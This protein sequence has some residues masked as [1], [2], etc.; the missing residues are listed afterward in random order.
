[1][2]ESLI[3]LGVSLA[4]FGL[5]TLK[6]HLEKRKK[7]KETQITLEKL[8]KQIDKMNKQWNDLKKKLEAKR[9][10]NK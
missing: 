6:D 10:S 8:D 7:E 9:D 5:N 2:I 1:M 4:S 3:S